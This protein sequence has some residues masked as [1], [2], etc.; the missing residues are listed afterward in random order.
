MSSAH[1]IGYCTYY[2]G[3]PFDENGKGANFGKC[4]EDTVSQVAGK[5]EN[6]RIKE[7]CLAKRR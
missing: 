3:N 6:L 1:E 5:Q 7:C 4:R 2:F